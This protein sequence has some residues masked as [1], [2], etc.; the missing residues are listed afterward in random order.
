[1]YVTLLQPECR[2]ASPNDPIIVEFPHPGIYSLATAK[3]FWVAAGE[4][5]DI[6]IG[7]EPL[8]IPDD[9]REFV[10]ALRESGQLEVVEMLLGAAFN[11]GRTFRGR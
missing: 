2:P 9:V 7:Y 5:P 4:F 1:M 3:Q 8:E 11:L 6:V 10:E